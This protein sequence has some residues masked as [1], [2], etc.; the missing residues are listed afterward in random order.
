MEKNKTRFTIMVILIPIIVIILLAGAVIAIF[1]G[2]IDIITKVS[3]GIGNFL[4]DPLGFIAKLA[5]KAW[6]TLITFAPGD[7]NNYAI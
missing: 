1:N 6:N 7:R 2:V 5:Q 3:E 4:N